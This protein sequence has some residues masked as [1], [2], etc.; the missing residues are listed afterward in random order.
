MDLTGAHPKANI[1]SM[2]VGNVPSW[3][4]SPARRVINS[5]IDNE[6]N[7]VTLDHRYAPTLTP[8]QAAVG[9]TP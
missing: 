8:G 6:L 2:Q 7:N 1:A 5:A 9:A 3:M 4:L